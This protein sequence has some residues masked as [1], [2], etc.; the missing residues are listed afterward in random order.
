MKTAKQSQSLRGK[1][2]SQ[3]VTSQ[4]TGDKVTV[5][6]AFLAE[7]K[8][9]HKELWDLLHE[10]REMCSQIFRSAKWQSRFV[11]SV[12][13]LRDL[14]AMQFSLEEG[15]G[16]FSEPAYVEAQISKRATGLMNDHQ[17]LYSEI[18]RICEWLQDLRYS[19]GLTHE[20]PN[21]KVRF[22]SFYDQ[23]QAHEKLEQELI[24]DIYCRDLGM[25]D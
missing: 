21:V 5:N 7:V 20:M 16:Y 18:S 2:T 3:P 10:A 8:T 11:E 1:K 9:I 14:F 17:A 13:E 12:C 24:Y 22:E 19:G 15:L 23:I 4:Q 25:G 6:G